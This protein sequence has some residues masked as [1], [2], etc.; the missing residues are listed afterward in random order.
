MSEKVKLPDSTQLD[1][2]NG[3]LES[4]N[5]TLAGQGF[6][7]KETIVDAVLA[8][9]AK[10]EGSSAAEAF[11]QS[12]INYCEK[13]GYSLQTI[14]DGTTTLQNQ[15]IWE[16]RK[17]WTTMPDS[18][19]EIVYNGSGCFEGCANVLFDKLSDSLT[20][21]GNYGF[22]YCTNLALTSLPDSLTSIGNYGFA[23][24]TNLALTS[25]PD[26]LTSIGDCAFQTCTNLALTSLPEG[27]T[28]IG[29]YAF[30]S[31]ANLALTSLPEGLT[32]IGKYAFYNNNYDCITEIPASVKTI[33]ERAFHKAFNSASLLGFKGALTFKG[34][35]DSIGANAF[36]HNGSSLKTINVPW[37]E[38]A[39][40]G[41]P[42]GFGGTINYNYTGG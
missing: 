1:T 42:W 7:T 23:N 36:N 14:E 10:W 37:A 6:V 29:N 40:A 33:G 26:S 16:Y 11:R 34:T 27:L 21:I 15:G 3:K 8:A 13:Q 35:P 31:C 38:G 17:Y 32:S 25:L 9:L 41:A 22:Y 39:V 28:S 20:S 5:T 19:T 4:I 2:L 12:M 24:C 30:Q 18:V